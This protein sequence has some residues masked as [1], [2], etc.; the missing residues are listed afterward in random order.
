MIRAGARRR[1]R[2]SIRDPRAPARAAPQPEIMITGRLVET[3]PGLPAE[4][5]SDT[6]DSGGVRDHDS[7]RPGPDTACQ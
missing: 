4:C 2:D 1:R 3:V 6:T 5:N 7:S